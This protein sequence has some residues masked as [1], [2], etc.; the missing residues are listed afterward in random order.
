[1]EQSR[2]EKFGLSRHGLHGL[3]RYEGDELKWRNGRDSK[4][5]ANSR[6]YLSYYIR[7][8]KASFSVHRLVWLYHNDYIPCLAEIDHI[9]RDKLNNQIENLRLVTCRQNMQNRAL[10]STG[11]RGVSWNKRIGRYQAR[12]TVKG[13]IKSLGY[14]DC[15]HEAGAKYREVS[16][17]LA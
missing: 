6:G 7:E 3:F 12:V 1:M 11:I 17:S 16:A 2:E 10:G 5:S 8:V 14:F 4:W 13:V 9:D 15:P